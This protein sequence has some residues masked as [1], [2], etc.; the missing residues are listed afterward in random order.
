MDGQVE[1]PDFPALT[2]SGK[3]S[4][5][6]TRIGGHWQRRPMQVSANAR[7]REMSILDGFE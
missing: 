5:A 3:S 6:Q 7:S 4:R 1:F 2:T